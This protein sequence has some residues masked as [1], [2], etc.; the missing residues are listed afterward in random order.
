MKR[1]LTKYAKKKNNDSQTVTIQKK[2]QTFSCVLEMDFKK[3]IE[4]RMPQLTLYFDT[5][6]FISR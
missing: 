6:E 4:K 3:E 1:K 2:C 5:C